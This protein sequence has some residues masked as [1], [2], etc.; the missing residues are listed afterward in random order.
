MAFAAFAATS[1]GRRIPWPS[2]TRSSC[3]GLLAI[4]VILPCIR[5]LTHLA[6]VERRI[7][8]GLVEDARDL[9]ESVDG[10]TSNTAQ[11]ETSSL[12]LRHPAGYGQATIRKLDT[13]RRSRLRATGD[14]EEP[15]AGQG[16]EWVVDRDDRTTGILGEVS[17]GGEVVSR[18]CVPWLL[19]LLAVQVGGC[20]LTAK[21]WATVDTEPVWIHQAVVDDEHRLHMAV[22]Y[23]G[24]RTWLVTA[25]LLAPPESTGN[26]RASREKPTSDD[27]P[28]IAGNDIRIWRLY[29]FYHDMGGEDFWAYVHHGGYNAYVILP[30]PPNWRD[31][32]TYFAFPAT[33]V[34]VAVDVLTFPINLAWGLYHM[35]NFPDPWIPWLRGAPERILQEE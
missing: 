18:R 35:D 8:P 5:V 32:T 21:L 1:G 3:R 27:L 24:G 6:G 14:R 15:L 34:T 31:W 11:M 7:C 33:V 10:N 9:Q 26:V 17:P 20:G 2:A 29:H 12:P 13:D 23:S 22:E 4:G 19:V 25:Q 30:A 16:V 28:G